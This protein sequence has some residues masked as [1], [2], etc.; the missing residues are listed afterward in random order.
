[1]QYYRFVFSI[2]QLLYRSEYQYLVQQ[3]CRN[4][5]LYLC[6]LVHEYRTIYGSMPTLT[7]LVI[8]QY[9]PCDCEHYL[10]M[11]IAIPIL[12][13][14]FQEYGLLF[15]CYIVYQ[16]YI[17]YISEGIYPS[18]EDIMEVDIQTLVNQSMGQQ[19]ED[20]WNSQSSGLSKT[21]FPSKQLSKNLSENCAICQEEMKEGEYVI[22]LPCN[23]TFHAKQDGCN[24]IE[25][26]YTKV[27]NCPLCKEP[28]K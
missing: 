1:M 17:Y 27:S 18:L 3:G 12:V 9:T 19:T 4:P 10:P 26:W 11:D 16:F 21:H 14:G 6:T 23:H 7:N 22:T 20:F 15:P 5:S 28:L 24:G 13:H 25:E 2:E 8:Y